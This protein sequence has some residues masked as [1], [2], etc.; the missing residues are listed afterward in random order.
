MKLTSKTRYGLAVMVLL[1][2]ANGQTVPLSQIAKRLGLSKIYL[3][4]VLSVLRSHQL[5]NAQKGPSGGY[6]LDGQADLW[7]ILSALEPELMTLPD[8]DFTDERM[9]QV[10]QEAIYQPI[11][12]SLHTVLSSLSLATVAEQYSE[13]PMYYI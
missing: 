13:T 5:V 11:L 3:E 4:Q 6:S 1:A 8:A 12:Q 10:L 7:T 2:K 9:N